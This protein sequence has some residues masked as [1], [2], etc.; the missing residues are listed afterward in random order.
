[1]KKKVFISFDYEKNKQYRYLLNAW[2]ANQEFDFSFRDNT[3]DEIQS[4]NIPTIKAGL[5]RKIS[6]SDCVLVIIGEEANKLHY[7]WREIGFRNWQNFEIAKAKE[8]GIPIVAVKINYTYESPSEILNSGAKWV[9]S[10]T[11]SEIMNAIRSV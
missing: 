6:T 3:P 2:N 7:S 4:Y 1:M 11:T 10:F 8:L 5:T 9:Y